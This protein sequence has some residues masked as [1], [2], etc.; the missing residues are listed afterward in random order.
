MFKVIHNPGTAVDPRF[1]KSG[2]EITTVAEI[3]YS[4][5]HTVEYQDW[6][7]TS[8]YRRSQTSWM[9]YSAPVDKIQEF[10]LV[11]REKAAYLFVTDLAECCYQSFSD[12]WEVFIAAMS[13]GTRFVAAEEQHSD[14][15]S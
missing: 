11:A 7:A 3:D 8:P 13:Q 5:F 4:Q 6:L 12:H 14:R 2:P 10:V 15:D 9:I 1:A